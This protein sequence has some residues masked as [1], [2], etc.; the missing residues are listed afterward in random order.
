M[1]PSIKQLFKDTGYGAKD[2]S[3]AGSVTSS[4]AKKFAP[5]MDGDYNSSPAA[6]YF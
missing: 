6:S 2:S 5:Y 3:I 4:N 1:D